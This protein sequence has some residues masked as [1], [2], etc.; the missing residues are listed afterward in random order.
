M[1][2]LTFALLACLLPVAATAQFTDDFADGDFTSNP[3]WT[4]DT[5][6]FAVVPFEADFVLRSDGL[7]ESDT[8][9]LATPSTTAFGTWRFRFRFEDN[10][11]TGK[12]TRVYLVANTDDL[13]GEVQGYYV[14]IGTNNSDEIRLYRQDGAA[15]DRT[16]LGDGLADLVT[17]D[18]GDVVVEVTR[19]GL[20]LWTV[21]AN[22]DAA[23]P[24]FTA[25]DDTYAA[26]THVGIWLKHTAAAGQAFFWDDIEAS[27]SLTDTTPPRVEQVLTENPTSLLVL[28]SESLSAAPASG[29]VVD[30]VIVPASATIAGASDTAV[31]L[32]FAEPFPNGDYTLAVSDVADL[33]G[34]VIAPN[35]EVPFAVAFDAEPPVLVSA[36]AEDPLRVDVRFSEP[37]AEPD[38]AAF[39]IDGGIGAPVMVEP[40]LGG[41]NRDWG[42][43][44]ATPL[45]D[46]TAYV[47]T[48]RGIEDLAGNVQPET[49]VA[50]F[51]GTPA[52]P[53]PGDIVVNE[54]M[55]DPPSDASDEYVELF[56]RTERAFDLSQ[57]VLADATAASRIADAPTFLL[58]GGY[59]VLVRD[60]AAFAAA[61]PAVP[62]VEVAPWRALNNGGDEVTL[63]FQPTDD[64]A[65]VEIDQVPYQSSWGGMDAAL[66]RID[67][68]GPS[69]SASNFA[70]TTD[71]RGGTPGAQNST[72]A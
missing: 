4:G 32:S 57:F 27:P 35:T 22:P 36:N 30:G 40:L 29:F 26:S 63:L 25:T 70:T 61:F 72:F 42:L 69:T 17:G 45:A 37:V 64:D 5:E 1:I 31:R 34:N 28:F 68:E 23:G 49:S 33:A 54:V 8:I 62:F 53:A 12:G 18:A 38:A 7:A 44:L 60:S 14:Q 19:D 58:P 55:Y 59:A 21:S 24:S 65:P 11:T 41:D 43:I 46:N 3:A 66:E 52:V 13:K 71:P 6:R 20:G 16:E 50:F 15:T 67:P 2:R 47:L 9:A 39:E 51:F 10:L 56:N 48:A